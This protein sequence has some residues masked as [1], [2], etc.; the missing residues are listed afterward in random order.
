MADAAVEDGTDENWFVTTVSMDW[1]VG[2]NVLMSCN[3]VNGKMDESICPGF[4]WDVLTC[5]VCALFPDASVNEL[6]EPPV[7]MLNDMDMELP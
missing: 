2:S 5:D 3:V 4:A 6:V 1:K 7:A